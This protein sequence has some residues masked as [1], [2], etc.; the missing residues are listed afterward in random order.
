MIRTGNRERV[1]AAA[2][3]IAC[4]AAVWLSGQSRPPSA[5]V[6]AAGTAD[7][8]RTDDVAPRF[9][10]FAPGDA[11]QGARDELAARQAELDAAQLRPDAMIAEVAGGRY[12]ALD[13]PPHAA[14][15]QS[16]TQH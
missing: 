6:T 7:A 11:Q 12:A 8:T 15:P 10:T 5:A 4:G 13:V 3:A 2:A 14:T 16:A 9:E 1:W